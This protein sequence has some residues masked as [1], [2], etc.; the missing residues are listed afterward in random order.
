MKPVKVE[1]KQVGDFFLYALSTCIW[2]RK[3]KAFLE[4][5]GIEYSYIFVDELDGEEKEKIREEMKKWNPSCSYPTLVVNN[6]KCI[7]GFDVD[8]IKK[9]FKA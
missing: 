6:E 1:G 3:T 7:V 8:A 4:E 5:S 2:C 9:E